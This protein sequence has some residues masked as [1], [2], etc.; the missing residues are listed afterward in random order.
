MKAQAE[1]AALERQYAKHGRGAIVIESRGVLATALGTIVTIIAMAGRRK[2][3]RRLFANATDAC[4]ALARHLVRDGCGC[5]AAACL[6]AQEAFRGRYPT[7]LK[8]AAQ[9]DNR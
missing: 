1:S 5:A 9:R 3:G 8:S 7:G 6:E 4:H 2:D